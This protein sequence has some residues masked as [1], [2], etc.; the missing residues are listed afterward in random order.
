MFVR[1]QNDGHSITGIR[2]RT[3]DARRHFP[4]NVKAV[5]LKLPYDGLHNGKRQ[6]CD[7]RTFM[8]VEGVANAFTA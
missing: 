5:D 7:S 1:L 3:S 6:S 8:N 4:T 2:I